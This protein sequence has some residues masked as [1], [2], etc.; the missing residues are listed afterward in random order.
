MT[1]PVRKLAIPPELQ[2][3]T[4]GEEICHIAHLIAE[5]VAAIF[6][7]GGTGYS[8]YQT[9]HEGWSMYVPIAGGVV[10]AIVLGV[11]ISDLT[12]GP[13]AAYRKLNNA[14]KG[15]LNLIQQEGGIEAN[16]QA[17]DKER[18]ALINRGDAVTGQLTQIVA[19][20]NA[21]AV[22]V[23]QAVDHAS[24]AV[25][26]LHGVDVQMQ[27]A[28]AADGNASAALHGQVQDFTKK[29]ALL[30]GQVAEAGKVI[31]AL[32]SI[33]LRFD[34]SVSSFQA[35][36]EKILNAFGALITQIQDN[37]PVIEGLRKGVSELEADLGTLRGQLGDEKMLTQQLKGELAA[38]NTILDSLENELRAI[39]TQEEREL[40]A[41]AEEKRTFEQ[42]HAERQRLTGEVHQVNVELQQL[43]AAQGGGHG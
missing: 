30:Q 40:Q 17:D 42:D 33:D 10:S 25:D 35:N 43:I 39:R 21:D 5:F 1:A 23:G 2:T 27:Q 32:Q 22:A 38:T 31:P 12:C 19:A 20:Q 29:V 34:H 18:Q 4:P 9:I 37:I 8:A 36:A 24:A 11:L 16:M 28:V 3:A 14:L 15:Y 7:L 13:G 6:A 41:A 26:Q